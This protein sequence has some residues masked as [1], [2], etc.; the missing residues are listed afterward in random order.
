MLIL[1]F[2]QCTVFIHNIDIKGTLGWLWDGMQGG[3]SHLHPI[4][5]NSINRT[6][7]QDVAAAFVSFHSVLSMH[8]MYHV[9]ES[10]HVFSA[11]ETFW[12]LKS[13][14]Y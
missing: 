7:V 4:A 13:W 14:F 11:R 5:P 6:K 2:S 8:T 9:P 1:Y 10:R 3:T 12:K